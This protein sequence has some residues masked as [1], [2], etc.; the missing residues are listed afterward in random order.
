L[1]CCSRAQLAF[2]HRQEFYDA[3]IDDFLASRGVTQ[4]FVDFVVD[5]VDQKVGLVAFD[6]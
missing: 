1:C 3:L 4:D 2:H 6:D 5:Y